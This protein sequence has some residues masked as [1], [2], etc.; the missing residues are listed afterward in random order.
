MICSR[1]RFEFD[2]TTFEAS[3][4]KVSLRPHMAAETKDDFSMTWSDLEIVNAE[5]AAPLRS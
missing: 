4:L 1:I 5:N 3:L 2:S